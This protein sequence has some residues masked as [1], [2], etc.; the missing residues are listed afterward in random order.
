MVTLKAMSVKL[1]HNPRCSKSR[2]ALALLEERGI[3]ADI[4]DYVNNPPSVAELKSILQKL[5]IEAGQWLR[6]KEAAA[7]ERGLTPASDEAAILKA[8][9]ENPKLI[10]RPVIITDK[11]ARI[12][13]PPEKILEVL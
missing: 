8:M 7:K 6:A 5:G 13:R 2:Q 10:E 12:G 3:S 4:I 1:Y 11:G 9:S